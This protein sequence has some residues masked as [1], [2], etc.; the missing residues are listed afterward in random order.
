MKKNLKFVKK[1]LVIALLFLF[2]LS[3]SSPGLAATENHIIRAGY[4]H[5]G[6][7]QYIGTVRIYESEATV[8][9][10][11]EGD[12]FTIIMENAEFNGPPTLS[13]RGRFDLKIFSGGQNCDSYITYQFVAP[14]DS[15]RSGQV[16]ID[17]ILDNMQALGGDI[18]ARVDSP[19]SGVTSG[20]FSTGGNVTEIDEAKQ[21]QKE[22]IVV[23]EEGI[24]EAREKN[25]NILVTDEDYQ[26]LLPGDEMP[27]EGGLQ[28]D[29]VR[30]KSKDSKY[31]TELYSLNL[32]AEKEQK[33]P[34]K[35]ELRIKLKDLKEKNNIKA[36]GISK[37]GQENLVS[38][39]DAESDFIF[40]KLN[41]MND[42]I[43]LVPG[44]RGAELVFEAE[45]YL[46]YEAMNYL[47]VRKVA[48]WYGWEVAWN[49]FTRT[50][51]LEKDEQSLAIDAEDYLIYKERSY[52]SSDFLR[53]KLSAITFELADK[54]ILK[55]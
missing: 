33:T 38:Y 28:V 45:E 44:S 30:E 9:S 13:E 47:P 11:R 43:S 16:I 35:A 46:K 12:I 20:Y 7:N 24:A 50:V 27:L 5:S 18:S 26:I 19:F 49:P 3:I 31:L 2:A 23:S 22:S 52:I 53:E 17:F 32:T 48:A 34:S 29:I 40:I 10:I 1:N 15:S 36:L 37:A 14:A 41:N 51:N 4:A 8:D 21:L 42:Q 39:Y 6:G 55:K 25:V 54:L